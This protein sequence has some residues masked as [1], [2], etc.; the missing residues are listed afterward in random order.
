MNELYYSENFQ[1]LKF[2][3]LNS[4]RSKNSLNVLLV[5]L[6]IKCITSHLFVYKI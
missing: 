6:C 5:C 2:L 4:L 3:D 1:I